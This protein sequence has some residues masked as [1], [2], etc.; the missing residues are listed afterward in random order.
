MPTSS[1]SGH[2][3][4]ITGPSGMTEVISWKC[5]LTIKELEATSMGSSGYEEFVVGLKGASFSGSC[6]GATMPTRGT[7]TATLVTASTGGVTIS[8]AAIIGKVGI[9]TPVDGKVTFDFDG[10]FTGSVT[11]L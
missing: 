1:I 6:Q 9:T 11:G 5:D 8:G 7:C 10:K 2:T 4:S 3:G